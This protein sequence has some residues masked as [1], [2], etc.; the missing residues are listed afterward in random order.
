MGEAEVAA[1]L[2]PLATQ[3]NVAASTQNQA[4][5]KAVLERPLESIGGV[6]R[7][8]KPVRLPFVLFEQEV[9]RV[10]TALKGLY[11]LIAYFRQAC[12]TC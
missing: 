6:V 12:V 11:W 5:Y 4:L 8:K 9:S 3:R 1:F 2:S 10:L 7:A